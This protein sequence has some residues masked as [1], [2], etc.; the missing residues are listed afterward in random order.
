MAKVEFLTRADVR[1]LAVVKGQSEILDWF[2]YDTL[3]IANGNTGVSFTFFQQA[4]GNPA[5]TTKEQT[6]MTIPGQLPSGYK[7]VCQ[8]III[9]PVPSAPAPVAGTGIDQLAILNAG[10]FEFNIGTRQYLEGHVKDLAG[11]ALTGV[12]GGQAVP[13]TSVRT[14][15]NGEME[16]SPVIPSTFNFNVLLQYDTAPNPAAALK[17]RCKLVG[18]LI[19]PLQG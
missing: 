18:K 2:L 7:F 16:Y 1:N 12:G 8:K 13:L 11:G 15:V 4:I 3:S 14:V 5:G 17:V 19:R 9:D 10:R 6:N